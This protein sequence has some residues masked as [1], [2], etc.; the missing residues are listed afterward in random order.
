[1]PITSR[2]ATAEPELFDAGTPVAIAGQLSPRP[3]PDMARSLRA[4]AA[5]AAGSAQS[6][7]PFR[8]EWSTRTERRRG[9]QLEGEQLADRV[10]ARQL[11]AQTTEEERGAIYEEHSK[12]AAKK[13]TGALSRGERARLQ[14][15]RWHIDRFQDADLGPHIDVLESLLRIQRSLVEEIR[16]LGRQV[17]EADPAKR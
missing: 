13:V 2:V 5:V 3:L 1:M 14:M 15:L 17:R 7:T 4:Q 10:R 9:L 16:I 12:L 11:A 8:P 6:P